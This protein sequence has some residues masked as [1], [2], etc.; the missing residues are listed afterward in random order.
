M[1]KGTRGVILGLTGGG[2]G[3]ILEMYMKRDWR[4]DIGTYRG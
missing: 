1:R 4:G 2:L 3:K